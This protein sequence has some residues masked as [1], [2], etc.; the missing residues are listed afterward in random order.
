MRERMGELLWSQ[1]VSYA[2]EHYKARFV[3]AFCKPSLRCVGRL[4]GTPCP[5]AFDV[6]LASPD[7]KRKLRLM[8]LDHERP[9]HLTCEQWSNAL[10]EFPSSW[11][12]GLDAGAL[13]HDL[14][15]AYDDRT[16]S[17]EASACASTAALHRAGGSRSTPTATP[18]D[19]GC[20]KRKNGGL[21]VGEGVPVSVWG[22]WHNRV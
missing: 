6:D 20:V 16:S 8:H 5:H 4:D 2:N 22:G 7:A 11:H 10:P 3:R 19:A 12:E 17:T 14:F 18:R 21:S 15:G 9:A 13:C 1:F